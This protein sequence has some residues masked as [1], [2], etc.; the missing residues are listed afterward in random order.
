MSEDRISKLEDALTNLT[1]KFS[2]FIAIESGRQERD[3]HQVE[4]NEKVLAHM[5]KVDT[6]YKPTIVRS[7]K[8]QDWVDN[9]LGKII[10]P[11]I[12]LAVLSAAGYNF[13]T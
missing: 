1:N 6:E 5:E 11:A 13:Y 3:K 9:F 10:F 12:I 8:Y 4:I 7:R 2:E